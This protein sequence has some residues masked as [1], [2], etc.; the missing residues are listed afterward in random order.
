MGK[1][2]AAERKEHAEG[3]AAFLMPWM[4]SVLALRYFIGREA[5][6]DDLRELCRN[7]S[8]AIYANIDK[9]VSVPV[10]EG[11]GKIGADYTSDGIR[12]DDIG[13]LPQLQ[14]FSNETTQQNAAGNHEIFYTMSLAVVAIALNEPFQ[15]D[16]KNLFRNFAKRVHSAPSKTF[17]RMNNK[18]ANAKDHGDP[19]IPKPRPAKNVDII[20][21]AVEV[22]HWQDVEKV[23]ERL[24]SQYRILRVKNTHY[25]HVSG[26][27]GY[28]SLLVNFAYH[29]GLTFADI[30]GTT[31]IWDLDKIQFLSF[32]PLGNA[33]LKAVEN[34]PRASKWKWGLQGLFH[35]ARKTPD[36]EVMLSGEVQIILEPYMVGRHLSHLLFEISRCETGADEMVSDF[37]GSTFKTK[38]KSA[39]ESSYKFLHNIRNKSSESKT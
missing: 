17:T 21:C 35:Q 12:Q 39:T 29:S 27:G 22:Q 33:W 15:V 23:F 5:K 26:F 32:D 19:S 36:A 13:L 30:F 25:P 16:M 24:R 7:R 10:L 37:A 9:D 2:G 1:G 3:A 34:Y 11:L 6:F 18:L 20:R 8:Q 38:D 28:R 4:G 14:Y 31:T